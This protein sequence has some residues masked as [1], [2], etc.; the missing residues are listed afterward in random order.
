MA[1]LRADVAIIG[2]GVAGCSAALHMA[3]A[4][5]AVVLLEKGAF[6]SQASGV[7][8]GGVR[9][10]GRDPVELPLAR[11]SRALWARMSELVGVDVEFE[12]KGHLKLARSEAAMAELENYAATVRPYGLDIHL[13]GRNALRMEYPWLGDAV[14]GAS[15]CADDGQANPRLVAPA[16]A[17]AARLAGADVR[18]HE[19]I[20]DV[21][22]LS[23]GFTLTAASGLE[24]RATQIVNTAGAWGGEIAAR[25]GE[26]VPIALMTPN[27][28]VTEPLP[29]FISRLIGVVG[30]GVYFNQTKRGNLVFGGG[31]GWGDLAQE[32]GRPLPIVTAETI[33]HAIACIPALSG[34][35]VIRS[36][37]GLEG[38]M[39]D[40]IPVIGPSHTTPGLWHAF[41]F[42]GHGFQLGP[43]VGAV[44]DELVRT[45]A[46][47]TPIAAFDIGRFA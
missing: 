21:A 43:A 39:P 8:A 32:R 37:T 31:Q 11:R 30:G 26:P 1:A 27:M 6:G 19:R 24:V 7:N 15:L 10:Q 45:G 12:P 16:F 47:T 33:G 38:V 44:L 4:G 36:W 46:T 22:R 42:S 34:A 23:S 5:L 2:G 41:G 25:F 18:E 40:R 28:I 3:R 35:Q 9:Q 29:P 17:R 20:I 13:V 14:V